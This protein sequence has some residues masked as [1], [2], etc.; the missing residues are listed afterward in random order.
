MDRRG[1]REDVPSARMEGRLGASR[2]RMGTKRGAN[3]RWKDRKSDS[4]GST[5]FGRAIC[6]AQLEARGEKRE[7]KDSWT[8]LAFI[9]GCRLTFGKQAGWQSKRR[10]T[11]EDSYTGMV[12][13]ARELSKG[14]SAEQQKQTVLA[15]FPK[16]PPL[17]RKLFPLSKW[18]AEVNATITVSMFEWLVGP[19]TIKEDEVPALGGRAK[20][21]VVV[22][23][24]RFLEES[25]CSGMCVNMCKAPMQTFFTEE[26]G[27][28]LTMKPNFEDMSC[29]MIFGQVPP[30]LEEDE[31]M[32]SPCLKSCPTAAAA[33]ASCP[34]LGKL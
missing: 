21:T 29:Q 8:D 17:F 24:C 4:G 25:G 34:S 30:P 27:M 5:S 19:S 31:A 16:I 3:G 28:P 6:R 14:K 32:N 12:E 33:L 22:E 7:Y 23:K 18:G 11:D 10:W 20:S 2:G 26:L 15:G 1:T 13:V 9:A